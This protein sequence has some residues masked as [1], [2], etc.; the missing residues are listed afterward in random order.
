MRGRAEKNGSAWCRLFR[1]ATTLPV[2]ASR[3]P[4]CLCR[5]PLQ[6]VVAPSSFS[7]SDL[8]GSLA[9]SKAESRI[10]KHFR[11]QPKRLSFGQFLRVSPSSF[12]K[13]KCESTPRE[14]G[15]TTETGNTGLRAWFQ[16]D[17]TSVSIAIDIFTL[18]PLKF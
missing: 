13:S 17:L 6:L 3:T 7:L 8:T 14:W 1:K 10:L 2:F 4:A 15:L 12:S 9:G 16:K 11:Y 18:Q 5:S